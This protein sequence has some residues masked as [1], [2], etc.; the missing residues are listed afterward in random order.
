MFTFISSFGGTLS[1]IGQPPLYHQSSFKRI[2][3]HGRPQPNCVRTYLDHYKKKKQLLRVN[4]T[5]RSLK[6]M[7]LSLA[8]LDAMHLIIGHR[9]AVVKISQIIVHTY[10][11]HGLFQPK[12]CW[13]ISEPQSR[14]KT[15]IAH[16]RIIIKIKQQLSNVNSRKNVYFHWQLWWHLIIGQP[17]LYNN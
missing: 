12:K 13:Y 14:V 8:A 6:K 17:S 2:P 15:V 7:L 3:S 9:A 11:N 1:S 4:S 5:L 16:I 10:P